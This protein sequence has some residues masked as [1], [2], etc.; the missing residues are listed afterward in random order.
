MTLTPSDAD[1]PRNAD[2]PRDADVP[3][4]GAI[5]VAIPA[6][7][8]GTR[9]GGVKK[10]FLSL[11]GQP[12]L[13]RSLLPFL[14]FPGVKAVVVALPPEDASHLPAFLKGIDA[15]VRFVAG[16]DTR[17]H[18]VHHALHALPAG[19]DRVLVHD[20]ARPL[21][22]RQAI[23]AC[24][25]RVEPGVGAVSGWPVVD[26]LQRVDEGGYVTDTPARDLLWHAHTPQAFVFDELVEAYRAALREGLAAT[27]EASVYRHFGGQVRMV[28]GAPW[29]LKVTH[30]GDAEFAARLLGPEAAR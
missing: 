16:G 21:V 8:M 9:L 4:Y 20:A 28:K 3:R 15:R 27:D 7:G 17:L 30:P 19:L 18:S 1:V 25:D 26:T 12:L 10:A 13:L 6:A 22:T 11:S 23:E 24:L 29:N 14:D 5:G 2:V